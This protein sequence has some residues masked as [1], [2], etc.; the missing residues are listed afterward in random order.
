M[1]PS[2]ITNRALAREKSRGGVFGPPVKTFAAEN[3][4]HKQLRLLARQ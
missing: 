4:S 3:Y 2:K 1:N